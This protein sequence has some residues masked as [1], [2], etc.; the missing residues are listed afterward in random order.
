MLADFVIPP[1]AVQAAAEVEASY[2]YF[3][4]EWPELDKP[5]RIACMERAEEILRA[6]Y[7]ALRE[8]I[9]KEA[10]EV[11]AL[12][13]LRVTTEGKPV[14]LLPFSAYELANAAAA[15]L[16]AQHVY[17]TQRNPLEVL[18]SGDWCNVLGWRFEAAA[19]AYAPSERPNA[20]P[21]EY[22][23]RALAEVNFRRSGGEA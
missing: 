19:I 17:D 21:A 23:Q 15:L 3:N 1:E 10:G 14:V 22:R 6:A 2:Y 4:R 18:N 11:S 5:A 8:T 12:P 16:A 20:T 9:L 13:T 7:P